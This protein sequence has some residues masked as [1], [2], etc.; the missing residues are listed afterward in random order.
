MQMKTFPHP[1]AVVRHVSG[2]NWV[3]CLWEIDWGRPVNDVEACSQQPLTWE[4]F[5]ITAPV[6]A[7]FGCVALIHAPSWLCA[8]FTKV[9]IQLLRS[10]TSRVECG[11]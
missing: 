9:S 3:C 7:V 2:H 6:K 5:I 1:Y 10:P 8:P 11:A 4:E